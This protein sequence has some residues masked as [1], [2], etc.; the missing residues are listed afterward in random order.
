MHYDYWVPPVEE[1]AVQPSGT[2]VREG[3]RVRPVLLEGRA[4]E[5]KSSS[6]PLAS[7]ITQVKAAKSLGLWGKTAVA[8]HGQETRRKASTAGGERHVGI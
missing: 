1:R 6:Q 4:Q 2:E 3:S 8:A 7:P 5:N